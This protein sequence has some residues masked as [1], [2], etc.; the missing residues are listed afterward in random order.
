MRLYFARHGESTANLV[1][2]FSNRGWK[3][4]LTEVGME[5]AHATARGLEGLHVERIYSSPL[6][7]AVRTAQILSETLQAPLE[8]SRA[9][10]EWDVGDYE[11]TADPAGWE[12]HR[13]VQNDWFIH[14]KLDSRMPGGESFCDIRDR[15]VPFVEASVQSGKDTD[16]NFVLVGHGG[17]YIAMLPLLFGNV[18]WAFARQRGFSYAAYALAE[19]RPGGLH[20]ISW[21]G[22]SMDPSA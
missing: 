9:L 7:R 10:R 21:C 5:Q 22:I 16:R 18:D 6:M 4:P 14:N 1:R 17:L 13:Q 20:C 15:F 19:P 2:E 12:L 8:I 3:H 11:G